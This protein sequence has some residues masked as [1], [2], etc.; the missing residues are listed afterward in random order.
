MPFSRPKLML[1]EQSFQDMLAAAFTIQEHNIRRQQ[2]LHPQPVCG[3]CGAPAKEGELRCGQC[4][5]GEVRPGEQLQRNWASL[6][7][8]SQEQGLWPDRP[9][10]T[11]PELNP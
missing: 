10:P 4:G 6:L 5:G 9:T 8:R 1:D 3:K 2:A 7:V 11:Q